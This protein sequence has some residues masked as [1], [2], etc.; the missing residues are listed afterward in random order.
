MADAAASDAPEQEPPLPPF[1]E[2]AAGERAREQ[3]WTAVQ[4]RIRERLG[5]ERYSIWFRQTELMSADERRMVVGVPNVII[6]QFLAERY[7]EPVRETVSELLGRPTGVQFEVAPG[8]FR[9]M[10]ARQE[11]ERLESEQ[12][13]EEPKTFQE[14]PAGPAA[15]GRWG[16]ENLIVTSANR[17]AYAA[18]REIAGQ[19]TPQ[20]RLLYVCGDYGLGKTA[21]L[22]AIYA[23]ADG[24]ERKLG[25]ILTSVED[26]CNEYYHAIQQKT[27]RMFRRRYRSSNMLIMDD[28]QFIQGK[29]GGQGELLHTVKHLLAEGGRVVLAGKPRPQELQEVDDAL[30]ALLNRAFPA[31]VQQ[32]S[33]AEWREVVEEL[34]RRKGLEATEKAFQFIA[35][36]FAGSFGRVESAVSCLALYAGVHGCGKVGPAE[37]RKA[38]SPMAPAPDQPTRLEDIKE[39]VL[40]VFDVPREKVMGK[41]RTRR[42]CTAR[43]VGMFLA[44][45]MTGASLSEIGRFFGGNSH[46]T[47]KH[48]VDKIDELTD[49]DDGM[50]ASVRR[51][52]D[53]IAN[54]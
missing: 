25:P 5:L 30:V 45:R 2:D 35:E 15:S 53:R 39:A 40:E 49:T 9:E 54:R 10:R 6:Q 44:R 3:F 29:A 8:L 33:P 38:L 34:A 26:W 20:F 41:C 22:Q 48:A 18:A 23:L 50:A 46:S 19:A 42:V 37:A 43:H 24:P 31:V 27:T 17:L 28:L 7:T 4:G 12:Q 14:E 1:P 36:K 21:L 52:K 13:T 32:P 11:Q 47:V 51:V 16:F